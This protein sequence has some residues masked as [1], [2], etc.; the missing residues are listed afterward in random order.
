MRFPQVAIKIIDKTQLLPGSLQKVRFIF[1]LFLTL[2]C[3]W[4]VGCPSKI[5]AMPKTTRGATLTAFLTHVK[6]S[7]HTY[8]TCIYILQILEYPGS[9][10]YFERTIQQRWMYIISISE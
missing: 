10:V 6:T 9:H 3:F 7:N 1:V 4:T 8:I 2:M 5:R